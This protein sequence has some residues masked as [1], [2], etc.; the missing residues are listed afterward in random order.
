MATPEPEAVSL[1]VAGAEVRLRWHPPAWRLESQPDWDRLERIRLISAAFDDGAALGVAAI[2]PRE[3]RGHGD[4]VA[5]ARFLDADGEEIATSEAL[6]S[7]EYDSAR[8]PRRLGVELWPDE[9]SPP[10]RIAAVRDEDGDAPS[11]EGPD[12]V[13]MSFRLDGVPGRGVYQT[14][15]HD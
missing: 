14:L 11:A 1:E 3:A 13:S 2:R 9:D 7:V 4:D 10:L 6:V 12:A 15:C 8:R 5:A